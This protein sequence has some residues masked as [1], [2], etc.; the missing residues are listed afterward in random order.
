MAAKSIS[1]LVLTLNPGSSSLRCALVDTA[2]TQRWLAKFE[3][4]GT[5]Q[6]RLQISGHPPR[7]TQAKTPPECLPLIADALDET[8]FGIPC[9][10]AHRIVHGGPNHFDPTRVTSEFIAELRG[11]A[12]FAP[13]HLPGAIALLDAAWKRWPKTPQV[14]CFDTCFHRELP[15]ASRLL[16]IPRRFAAQGI[17]RYGFHGLA[18][19][20]VLSALRVEGPLPRRLILAHL[21]NGASLAAVRDGKSVDTTMGFTPASGLVMSTRSG[22]IDAGLLGFLADREKL[23]GAALERLVAHESGLLGLSET[24]SDTRDLLECEAADPRAAEALAVYVHQARKFI[25]AFAA[26]LGG[27]DALVF[28]GGVG[29]NSP[30]LRARICAGF[31]YLGVEFDPSAND[32]NAA[33]VSRASSRVAVRIVAADEERALAA[34]A[35]PLLIRS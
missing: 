33:I 26:V 23:D 7:E 14:A 10:V 27:V 5:P 11:I 31:D 20:S 8:G 13:N 25:G 16:P 29:E 17:H 12:S 18:F 6:A 34:A 1:D 4:L 9:G 35:R 21:G 2:G 32:R 24:S 19:S 15:P 28:S 3:R 22:D 30:V